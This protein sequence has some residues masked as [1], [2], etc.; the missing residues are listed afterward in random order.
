MKNVAIVFAPICPHMCEAMWQLLGG[1]GLCCQQKLPEIDA[2]HLEDTTMQVSIAVNGK[3]KVCLTLDKN[4]TEEEIINEAKKQDK[5]IN[6][7]TGKDVK[8][9]IVVNS[10]TGKMVNFVV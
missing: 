5:V 3:F 4:L 2:K 6:A 8:K 1:E 7:I 9:T 10:K